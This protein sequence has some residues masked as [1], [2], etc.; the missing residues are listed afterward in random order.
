MPRGENPNSRN[1]LKPFS[2]E[3]K[4]EAREVGRR[5]GIKSGI[6]KKQNKTYAELMK[7]AAQRLTEK[8]FEE[9]KKEGR[10]KDAEHIAEVSGLV[11]EK[12]NIAT[13]KEVDAHVRL[14]AIN[15]IIDRID[16]KPVQKSE[17]DIDD[18]TKDITEFSFSEKE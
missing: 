8:M 11:Y 1:N 4:I 2:N 3:T 13:Q 18:K 12:F 7:L 15:S 16:G 6:I 9:A 5:G 10:L 14:K 17:I